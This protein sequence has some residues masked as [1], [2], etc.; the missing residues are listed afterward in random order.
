MD[1][2]KNSFK[3]LEKSFMEE[4]KKSSV[5]VEQNVKNT[6]DKMELIGNI[7]EVFIPKFSMQ[8]STC[9]KFLGKIIILEKTII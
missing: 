1:E 6:T 3:L 4:F 9:L 5:E 8:L 7:T 2:N